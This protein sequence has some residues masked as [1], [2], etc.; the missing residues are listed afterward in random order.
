MQHNI[1][2]NIVCYVFANVEDEEPQSQ[3]HLQLQ[4]TNKPQ[5]ER[6]G[7]IK[8]LRATNKGKHRELVRYA[9]KYNC[10]KLLCRR[11]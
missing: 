7:E 9:D 6:T 5:N 10:K 1:W 11:I 3:P 4:S 2:Q 8:P